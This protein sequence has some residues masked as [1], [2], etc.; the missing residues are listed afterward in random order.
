MFRAALRLPAEEY[1]GHA[2]EVA[3]LAAGEVSLLAAAAGHVKLAEL[4]AQLA[5]SDA[6]TSRV[7]APM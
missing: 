6:L 7:S 3:G 2:A 1:R 5:H 4:I